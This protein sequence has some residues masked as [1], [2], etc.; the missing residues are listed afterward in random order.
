MKTISRI[1]GF[2]NKIWDSRNILNFDSK[3]KNKQSGVHR[4]IQEIEKL[5]LCFMTKYWNRHSSCGDA[6]KTR[7]DF[8][9]VNDCSKRHYEINACITS[10]NDLHMH[11]KH[12]LQVLIGR[13]CFMLNS[14]LKLD[15]FWNEEKFS[16]LINTKKCT[17]KI[18]W[19][20][21]N[22]YRKQLSLLFG[23]S[24]MFI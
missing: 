21:Y 7:L 8:V 3:N 11:T 12:P 20:E 6:R 18:E 16:A 13:S 22:V 24:S 9:H 17:E 10:I 4:I 23:S 14:K 1:F 15:T 19:S 2:C 5:A